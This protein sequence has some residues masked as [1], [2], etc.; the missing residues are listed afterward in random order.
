M[1]KPSAATA[2]LLLAGMA[3]GA[4][5]FCDDCQATRRNFH[6]LCDYIMKEKREMPT[7]FV[8]GYYMR[9]LVAGYEIF[10]ER[11]YLDAAI[12][13]A[14]GLLKRQMPSGY[15]GTG[16]GRI[17]LADTASA[18]GEFIVLDKHVNAARRE[19]YLDA[20]RTHV[21]AI[22]R[23]GLIH[24][25]G[26]LGTGWRL[27][28]DGKLAE[29]YRD[30]YT[31]ASG[32]TGGEVFTWMYYKTHH[33]KYRRVAYEALR[34]ILSTM[35]ADGIIPYN[36]KGEFADLNRHGDAGNDYNLWRRLPYTTSSYVGEGILSFDLYS[37]KPEWKDEIRRGLKPHIEFLLRTQHPD[38]TW[39]DRTPPPEQRSL[40]AWEYMPFA[41]QTRSPG[42]INLLIWYHQHVSPDP[43]VAAAVK[44]FDRFLLDPNNARSY[45]MLHRGAHRSEPPSN[46]PHTYDD[47]VTSIAG[48]ALAD[49]ISPGVD[50]RW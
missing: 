38:G 30:E 9:T 3:F 24:P 42:I 17:Y 35:N 5:P 46:H 48:R 2:V 26:A 34:W 44:K 33:D 1:V 45:G 25:S 15:W 49:I 43:R 29:V 23:D 12:A 18:L 4:S 36:L 40:K 7:I 14:D 21:T 22:E 41:D 37:S 32:L 28:P 47:I 10:G 27:N 8:A 20:L 13:H 6:D 11:R 50:A 39:M 19:L 16:Y 31:I